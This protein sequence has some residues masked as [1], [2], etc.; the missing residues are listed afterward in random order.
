MAGPGRRIALLLQYYGAALAGSQRQANAPTVQGALEDAVH[1]LTGAPTRCDFAGR[2]DAGVHALGQVAALTTTATVP[3]H[4]WPRGLNHFL[5]ADIAIQAAREVPGDFDPRRHA[6]D[7]TYCYRVRLAPQ[8][9][10]IWER[11]AWVL[12]G[13]LDVEAMQSALNVLEGEHDFAAFAGRTDGAGTVRTLQESSLHATVNGLEFRFRAS[14]FLPHQV[15]HTVGQVIAVGRGNAS[16]SLIQ[17]LLT[18][19]RTGAAGPAAPP[20][21]LYLVRVRYDLAALQG[22]APCQ[23]S[24]DDE[25]VCWST[26]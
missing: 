5:P 12:S 24:E 1:S 14:G 19:P 4:R 15:R 21:G 9:Q 16:L 7:R 20:Q 26:G 25:D 23:R 18:Q 3:L 22:W 17:E 2:T 8:R 11:G 10:P 13:P 6:V